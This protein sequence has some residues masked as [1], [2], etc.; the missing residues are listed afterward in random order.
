MPTLEPGQTILRL[1]QHNWIV[2]MTPLV[3]GTEGRVF[4][5]LSKLLI[6]GEL[7]RLRRCLECHVFF[8]STDGRQ[9]F[10]DKSHQRRFDARNAK[11]RA[12]GYREREKAK[13]QGLKQ[14][15]RHGLKPDIN[16][17]A[18]LTEA[19]RF[20]DSFEKA[21]GI[22]LVFLAARVI[23]LQLAQWISWEAWTPV[24]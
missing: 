7:G 13:K 12:K 5:V 16:E 17:V 3:H 14:P 23:L 10:C 20:C 18:T 11:V 9:K 21:K 19:Q 8:A 6:T 2:H 4:M 15:R 1:G 24:I 22:V